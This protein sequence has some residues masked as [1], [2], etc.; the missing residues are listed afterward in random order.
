[1]SNDRK[2][3]SPFLYYFILSV[4]TSLIFTIVGLLVFA[5]LS[6]RVPDT[7]AIAIISLLFL[8]ECAIALFVSWF[9]HKKSSNK[10]FSVKFIGFSLGRFYGI[11]IGGLLGARIAEVLRQ[12]SFIGFIAGAFTFYLA[13]RWLGSRVSTFISRQIDKLFLIQES[14][15]PK[16]TVELIFPNKISAMF[17]V[18]APLL[19]VLAGLLLYYFDIPIGYLPELLPITRVMVIASTIFSISYPWFM[20]SRWRKK[21]ELNSTSPESLIFT[22]GLVYSMVPAMAGIIL[23]VGMGASIAELCLFAVI[24]SIAAVVWIAKHPIPKEQTTG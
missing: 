13:G 8:W 15:E 9:A 19:F 3:I 7:F 21:S 4:L 18:F 20:T 23:F 14:Q 24:S 1:M 2:V 11:F 6:R 17:F 10:D 22:L 5:V 16:K 12:A